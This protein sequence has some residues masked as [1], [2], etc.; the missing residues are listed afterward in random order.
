MTREFYP[1]TSRK[2]AANQKLM[3]YALVK[4]ASQQVPGENASCD[5]SLG[6]KKKKKK[7]RPPY[8]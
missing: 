1:S 6:K 7:K 5:P 4:K 8:V 3:A 2:I